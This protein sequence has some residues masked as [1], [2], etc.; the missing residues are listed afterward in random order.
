[1]DIDAL[2]AAR[3]DEWHDLARLSKKSRLS[4]PEADELIERYQSG[5]RDLSSIRTSVG[6]SGQGE[7]LSLDL[8]RARRAFTGV[9]R[10]VVDTLGEFFLWSLPAALYRVRWITVV[11]TLVSAGIAVAVGV[12]L[13]TH[14]ELMLHLG[15]PA[16]LRKYANQSF[17]GY[18]SAHPDAAFAGQVWTHNATLT[19]VTIAGGITGVLP[20]YEMLSNAVNVGEAGAIVAQYGRADHFWLYIAPHGQLELYSVFTAGA[21]GFLLFWALVAPGN[22][23]RLQAL[24]EDGRAFFTIVIGLVISLAMSGFIEGFIT[25]QPWPWPLKIGIGTFALAIFLVYQW[26]LGRRAHRAG[27]TGDLDEF[28]AGA[29]QLV[30]G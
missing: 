13:Y 4:G 8:S 2:S 6:Q 7:Q 30:A 10:N 9:S 5:A 11:V 26:V 27:R 25:R 18:Y 17:V 28:E 22:R 3:S 1:M 16:S 14:P 23:T 15:S 20:A 21:A 24:A 29:K 12:W 19:A